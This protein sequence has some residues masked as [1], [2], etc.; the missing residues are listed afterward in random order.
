MK[1]TTRALA[2]IKPDGVRQ[3]RTSTIIKGLLDDGFTIDSLLT[4]EMTLNEAQRLYKVHEGKSFYDSLCE[5]MTS[6]PCIWIKLTHD[7][8]ESCPVKLRKFIEQIRF[9]YA[10]SVQ[11]N[12]IHGSDS[13][14]A[15]EYELT[16]LGLI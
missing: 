10:T 6:G 1:N 5:F 11:H 4:V 14:E 7:A 3:N 8:P 9:S 16:T 15:A 12:V 13:L 2:I